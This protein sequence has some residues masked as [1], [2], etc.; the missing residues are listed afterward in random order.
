VPSRN[1][2][3]LKLKYRREH[4]TAAPVARNAL[5]ILAHEID[6]RPQRLITV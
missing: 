3:P 2:F 5:A 4:P 6:S 1:R